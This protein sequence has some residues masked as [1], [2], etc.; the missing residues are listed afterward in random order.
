VP[1]LAIALDALDA[2]DAHC[3]QEYATC[4]THIRNSEV[5]CGIPDITKASMIQCIVAVVAVRLPEPSSAEV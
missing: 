3:L 5:L 1:C 2:L 4:R